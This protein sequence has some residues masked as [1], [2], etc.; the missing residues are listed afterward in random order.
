MAVYLKLVHKCF[1]ALK[2]RSA[3][4][5]AFIVLSAVLVTAASHAATLTPDFTVNNTDFGKFGVG[6]MRDSGL[7]TLVVS[8]ITG[9]VTKAV[10]YWHGPTNSTDTTVNANVNFQGSAITGTNIGVSA[11]NSWGFV[12]SQA[13]RADVTA[14]VIGNG[15]YSLGNFRK[16]NA[17]ANG[18]ELLV[19]YDDGNTANNRNVVVYSGN[20]GNM[21][22][23]NP[24]DAQG[25]GGTFETPT[26]DSGPAWLHLAVSDGQGGSSTDSTLT[27]GTWA[28]FM[29][30]DG[31]SVGAVNSLWD[32]QRFDISSTLSQ[33][34]NTLSYS[35]PMGQDAISLI[36]A[37][38]DF[39]APPPQADLSITK[40]DGITNAAP[41]ESVIYTIT[42][43]NAGPWDTPGA[44]VT[45]TLPDAL[46]SAHW[47]CAGA[48]GGTCTASGTGN[49]SDSVTLPVGGS[50]TYTVTATVN[51]SA[52]GDLSNTATVT[53]PV[54]I[55]DPNLS[56]NSATDTDTLVPAFDLSL[57]Q[58]PTTLS[59][60]VGGS[61]TYT[62]TAA[63]SGPSHIPA[64]T[65]LDELPAALSNASW[66]CVATGGGSCAASGTGAI[67]D[68]I[69]LP[70]G[71][72]ATYT[73][74][75]S[76]VTA[77]TQGNLARLTAPVGVA[78]SNTSNN[79]T[80]GLLVVQ[81]PIQEIKP[82]PAL[83][84]LGVL[85]LTGWVA[86]AAALTRRKKSA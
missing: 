83:G 50:V 27:V 86:S 37:A 13:Y 64:A 57:V 26:Y 72:T 49:L 71:A 52:N 25:W 82:V 17:R 66:T 39:A 7:G 4:V 79:S 19:F 84:G 70:A 6:S 48:G 5:P 20:D 9:T 54:G 81:V 68:L 74:V 60:T 3:V 11:D 80:S 28:Q 33:G 35:T 42:A 34:L 14:L 15:N 21:A 75:A 73:V 24:P 41:G 40:T 32:S 59:A 47:T 78:E 61:V 56:N 51:P 30:F 36:V 55:T 18:A 29:V 8:G 77:G 10:L 2:S 46:I 62:L 45:D 23:N 16:S 67:S 53:A 63:N 22:F 31:S 65:L 38:L 85:L 43:S 12:N 58:T 69:D 1:S 76:V 44:T